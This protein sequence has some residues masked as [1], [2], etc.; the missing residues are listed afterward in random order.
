MDLAVPDY[1]RVYRAISEY[2]AVGN[3]CCEISV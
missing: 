2:A 1:R 3:I